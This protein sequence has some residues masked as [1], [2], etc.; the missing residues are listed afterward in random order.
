MKQS[1]VLPESMMPDAHIQPGGAGGIFSPGR[2]AGGAGRICAH[3][4][5]ATA[6]RV[7]SPKAVAI[8]TIAAA[9]CGRDTGLGMCADGPERPFRL[10][11]ELARARST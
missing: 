5:V 8:V 6:A 11:F 3:A 4:G 1:T 9:N 10:A 7:C 2:V